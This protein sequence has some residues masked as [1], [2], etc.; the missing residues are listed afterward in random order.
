MNK[1]QWTEVV[2]RADWPATWEARGTGEGG[3]PFWYTIERTKAI[4]SEGTDTYTAFRGYFRG[5][6]DGRVRIGGYVDL[7]SAKQGAEDSSAFWE[8][9]L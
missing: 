3:D 9:R 1:L 7:A 2:V 5:Q 6:V 4:T 8:G